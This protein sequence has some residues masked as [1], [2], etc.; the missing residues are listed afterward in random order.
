MEQLMNKMIKTSLLIALF[1]L[2]IITLGAGGKE[3]SFSPY[4]DGNGNITLPEDFRATWVHLGTIFVTS[5]TAI[6]GL[7]KAAPGSGL[8]DV[9]TQPESLRAYKKTSKWADGTVIVMESR[10]MKWDDVPTGHVIYG[11]KPTDWFVMVKDGKGRFK[12]S[13][14]WGDGWGWALFR[15]ADPK[16]NASTGYKNDCLSCHEVAKDTDWVFIDGYPTLR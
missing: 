12:N 4:V 11:G 10:T 7:G 15:A 13:P 1:L 9:Y 2:P 5:Q 16:K 3:A 8:H 14:N 6:P